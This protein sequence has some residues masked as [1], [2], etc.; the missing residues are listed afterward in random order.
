MNTVNGTVININVM[1]KIKLSSEACCAICFTTIQFVCV[2]IAC[3][4]IFQGCGS[5]C[6][7]IGCVGYFV[8][9][10]LVEVAKYKVVHTYYRDKVLEENA[11]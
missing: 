1:K 5:T 3:A 8:L 2:V 4:F 11:E 9:A 7:I 6:D 10:S